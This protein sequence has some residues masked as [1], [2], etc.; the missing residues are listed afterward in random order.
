[1]KG[2]GGELAGE[3]YSVYEN[4]YRTGGKVLWLTSVKLEQLQYPPQRQ[5]AEGGVGGGL[6]R[7]QVT[8]ITGRLDINFRSSEAALDGELLYRA[9][10]SERQP[11]AR[12]PGSEFSVV[13]SG[14]FEPVQVLFWGRSEEK[15]AILDN[16][17][18]AFWFP[19]GNCKDLEEKPPSKFRPKACQF[20]SVQIR[21]QSFLLGLDRKS[22]RKNKTFEPFCSVHYNNAVRTHPNATGESFSRLGDIQRMF[23]T[24]RDTAPDAIHAAELPGTMRTLSSWVGTNGSLLPPT[25]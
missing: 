12:G 24:P 11:S 19:R 1:M 23:R 20:T 4:T 7:S 9:E 8:A 3:Y 15:T 25:L 21:K 18:A 10:R 2:G 16:I 13:S 22:V 14:R 6:S 5:I 17:L